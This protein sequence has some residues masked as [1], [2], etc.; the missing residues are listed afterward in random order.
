MP[1][2]AT[3]FDY[4]L[5]TILFIGL[6][7]SFF[8]WSTWGDL[9]YSTNAGVHD[10]PASTSKINM[11]V[12]VIPLFLVY[13]MFTIYYFDGKPKLRELP[14]GIMFLSLRLAINKKIQDGIDD[15]RR[16]RTK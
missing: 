6:I 11:A 9:H 4:I 15:Y 2:K 8:A 5:T 7:L 3:R 12:Y 13:E 1:I 14:K 10:D 16:W